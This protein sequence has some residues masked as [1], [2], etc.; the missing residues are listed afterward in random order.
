M[1]LIG[2]VLCVEKE[3]GFGL[4]NVLNVPALTPYLHKEHRS[5]KSLAD[6]DYSSPRSSPV[7]ILSLRSVHGGFR[8]PLPIVQNQPQYSVRVITCPP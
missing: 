4:V 5:G 8:K 6:K 3:E 2:L 1:V 7:V